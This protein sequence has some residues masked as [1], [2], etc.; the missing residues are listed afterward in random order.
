MPA[1]LHERIS[2]PIAAS[3]SACIGASAPVMHQGDGAR[4]ARFS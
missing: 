4:A 1:Y 3:S 2:Q